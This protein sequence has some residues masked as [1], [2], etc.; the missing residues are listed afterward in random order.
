[1]SSSKKSL[2]DGWWGQNAV[3]KKCGVLK[4]EK[5]QAFCKR[6]YF[7][8]KIQQL[9][10]EKNIRSSIDGWFETNLIEQL[11]YPKYLRW[12]Q[13]LAEQAVLK[14][15]SCRKLS[16]WWLILC[17]HIYR[18]SVIEKPEVLQSSIIRMMKTVGELGGA[19]F[20]S[21]VLRDLSLSSIQMAWTGC[22]ETA[23]GVQ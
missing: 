3:K 15:R 6:L 14:P 8:A 18:Y 20:R 23:P 2:F 17:P 11:V 10:L 19:I 13:I 12:F 1:M 7:R 9:F 4:T 22:F 16:K 5:R 21:V